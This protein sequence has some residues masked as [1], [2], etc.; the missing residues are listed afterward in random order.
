MGSALSLFNSNMSSGTCTICG[1]LLGVEADELSR[2]C[3]GHCWGCVGEA[4]AN[5]GDELSLKKVL[6]EWR[7]GLRPNWTPPSK[8]DDDE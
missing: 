4:E 3:G 5:M 2:D 7:R 6:E 8:L 1:R